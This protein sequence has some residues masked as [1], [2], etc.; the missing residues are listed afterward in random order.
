MSTSLWALFEPMLE[1][2]R[3]RIRA[4]AVELAGRDGVEALFAAI[5]RFAIL[6]HV[7]AQHARHALLAIVAVGEL[8]DFLGEQ[9]LQALIECAFYAADSRPPWSEPP[10]ITVP[11]GELPSALDF[12]AARKAMRTGDLPWFERWLASAE[13][14]PQF[15]AE[16]FTLAASDDGDLGH[17]LVVA[18]AAWKLARRLPPEARFETLRIAAVEWCAYGGEP[19]APPYAGD[20]GE[21]LGRLVANVAREHGSLLSAHA[22]HLFDAALFAES[23]GAPLEAIAP[24]L[25]TL[26]LGSHAQEH[27]SADTPGDELTLPVYSYGRDLA[28]YLEA[29]A[30]AQRLASGFG[31]A[32]LERF[33]AFI[34]KNLNEGESLEE[35]SFV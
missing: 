27:P 18:C 30:I 20:R 35:W 5:A 23:E 19:Y 21:L 33:R 14:N 8:R 13:Q 34:L 12:A 15:V 10:I 16:Y 25:G 7:P 2:D 6:A 4:E 17:K 24:V 22:V 28:G 32:A 9:Y 31:A 29:C 3:D 26:D 1:R 11:P